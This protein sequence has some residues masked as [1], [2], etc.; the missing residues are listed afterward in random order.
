MQRARANQGHEA[1]RQLQ[2]AGVVDT[3]ITQNVDGL[4]Q[5]AGSRNVINLHGLSHEVICLSCG[6]ISDRAD[7]HQRLAAEN[8][9]WVLREATPAPDGD[10]ELEVDFS[11]FQVADCR[12]CGGL[13]KPNAVFFG[14]SVPRERVDAA[15]VAIENSGGLLVVGSSLM[16]FSGFRF[17]RLAS[18]VGLSIAAV[19]IGRT[20]A[21]DLLDLKLAAPCGPTLADVAGALAQAP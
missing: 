17:A 8:P 1:I 21:D 7:F 5:A 4:H 14:E 19:N 20:R 13:I 6:D 3:V 9:G 12:R 10:A 16:V 2:E 11:S 18:R 15:S